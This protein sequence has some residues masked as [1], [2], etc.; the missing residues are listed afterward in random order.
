MSRLNRPNT[1]IEDNLYPLAGYRQQDIVTKFVTMLKPIEEDIL[2]IESALLLHNIPLYGALAGGFITFFLLAY[3][4]SK[5]CFPSFVSAVI[6]V[7][8]FHLFYVCGGVDLLRKLYKQIPE[9]AEDNKR[10]VRSLEEIVSFIWFPLLW[11][12][13]IGFFVYRT[14]KCPNV[15]DTAFLIIA[16]IILG[17]LG[18]LMNFFMLCLIAVVLI[19]ALP[20]VLTMT[21]AGDFVVNFLNERKNK[22]QKIGEEPKKEEKKE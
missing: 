10:R 2:Q 16:T 17:S 13:R 8:C 15:I 3:V 22:T 20:G 14:F 12:W 4:L 11:G 19:L 21:P 6:L 18:K 7:P 5:S 9:L 1:L